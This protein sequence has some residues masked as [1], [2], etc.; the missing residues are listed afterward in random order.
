MS[1]ALQGAGHLL[2]AVQDNLIDAIWT[3]RPQRPSTPLRVLGLEY[4]GQ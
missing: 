4:T 1:K 3:E 2:V